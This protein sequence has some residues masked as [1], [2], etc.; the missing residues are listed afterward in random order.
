M[1]RRHI[2]LLAL[3]GTVLV[4]MGVFLLLSESYVASAQDTI[5]MQENPA[6]PGPGDFIGANDCSDCHRDLRS[7]HRDTAHG[8]T[9]Q[10]ITR[11]DTAPILADFSQGDDL[12]MVTF[13]GESSARAFVAADIAYVIG[14]SAG[15]QRYLFAVGEDSYLVLP[16]EWDV[17]RGVWQPYTLAD[18]W[19][20]AA[21]DWG[22][23]CA[24]CHVTGYDAETGG[25]EEDGVQCE[26]CHG[27]G[28]DHFDTA[29]DAGS[30]PD[31]D[32]LID[33]RAS[34]NPAT[35]PQVC[36]QC[37]S[38]GT[39]VSGQPFPVGYYP[40]MMLSDF[41]TLYPMDDSAYWYPTGHAR[42][43][44]M[45]YNEWLSDGH[46]ASVTAL[47]DSGA[48]VE[49]FC[50]T[51]H[52]ADYNTTA[53]QIAAV[54]AGDREGNAP[55]PVTGATAQYGVTCIT[56]HNPHLEGGEQP[57][58]LVAEANAM[59]SD[60]H[61]NEAFLAAG[62]TGVHRP[63]REMFEGIQ[64]VAQVFSRPS[65]HFE[66][67]DGPDC[68]T[69]HLPEVPVENSIRLSHTFRPVLPGDALN[70]DGVVDSCV[71]CH[72]DQVDGATMQ[73]LIDDVQ[74]DTRSRLETARAAVNAGTPDWVITALD[75]VEGD[76]SYG[77]H[78]YAYTDALLDAVFTELGLF[79]PT[80]Q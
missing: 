25:W 45:Q 23:N 43:A 10:E 24:Y 52:S 53:Q 79:P 59:C 27:P 57:A 65:D 63:S 1:K 80:G 66:V 56:C 75:F 21:Y 29:D 22:Q 32:E 19:P 76:G 77:V 7:A 64:I 47:R 3:S 39:G 51:C 30:R 4:C 55:D 69:C 58:Q 34:I 35:D 44:N 42:Q 9:L 2:R 60:C 26:A 48:Q 5:A 73:L 50:L 38:R 17:S 49:A 6:Q 41:W 78:N 15:V 18:N 33:I 28:E 8:Q 54:E 36:G 31:D 74:A 40:G 46:A 13:P 62:G 20:D 16:A 37:H 68:V 61:S 67:A 11:G 70:F 72:G 71:G 12:R 14:G